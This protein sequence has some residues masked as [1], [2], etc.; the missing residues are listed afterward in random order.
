MYLDFHSHNGTPTAFDGRIR[1]DEGD[2]TTSGGIMAYIARKHEFDGGPVNF[3]KGMS[4]QNSNVINTKIITGLSPSNN[5]QIGGNS[6]LSPSQY[7]A[8]KGFTFTGTPI[9]QISMMTTGANNLTCALICSVE[10]ITTTGFTFNIYNTRGGG[11]APQYYNISW[12]A[13][14]QV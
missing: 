3:W 13:I 1:C 10:S 5:F 11:T 4:F 7:Q 6:K 14:G 12:I 9:V 8:F 2:G